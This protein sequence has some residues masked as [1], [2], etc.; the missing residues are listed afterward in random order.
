LPSKKG[1][2][3]KRRNEQDLDQSRD[4]ETKEKVE[5]SQEETINQDRDRRTVMWLKMQEKQ[6][7]DQV[8]GKREPRHQQGMLTLKSNQDK[9]VIKTLRPRESRGSLP[10]PRDVKMPPKIPSPMLLSLLPRSS[11]VLEVK[12][13]FRLLAAREPK[14][15]SESKWQKEL[16]SK[17]L[18]KKSSDLL[19]SKRRKPKRK[20]SKSKSE[21]KP[22]REKRNKDK[23]RERGLRRNE[24]KPKPKT[25]RRPLVLLSRTRPKTIR[26]EQKKPANS[27][28][29]FDKVRK[30]H[31]RPRTKLESR[32]RR[33]AR[34]VVRKTHP[35]QQQPWSTGLKH[36]LPKLRSL[37]Q[38]LNK[39]KSRKLLRHHKVATNLNH[40]PRPRRK[41]H[42]EI[43]RRSQPRPKNLKLRPSKPKKSTLPQ[44]LLQLCLLNQLQNPTNLLLLKRKTPNMLLR[45][46]TKS[47]KSQSTKTPAKK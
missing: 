31:R 34:K 22:Q 32:E 25:L 6:K 45:S 2:E 3:P 20:P 44:P 40:Q 24:L 36:Q 19:P 35:N 27:R 5:S 1:K 42:E 21:L 16:K 7:P 39:L 43:E 30:P 10:S 14:Q 23:G 47:Q 41:S 12:W 29:Q 15:D 8:S 28:T 33:K 17:R 13:L 18:T 11:M 37:L 9:V 26:S 38:K 46:S 4:K